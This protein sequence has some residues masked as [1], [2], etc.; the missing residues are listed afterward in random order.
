MGKSTYTT[1][2]V[3]GPF[4]NEITIHGEASAKK[5]SSDWGKGLTPLVIIKLYNIF[6]AP[7]LT[8][9]IHNFVQLW[10]DLVWVKMFNQ[11]KQKFYLE[12]M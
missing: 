12:N 10:N 8:N 9:F 3:Q 11:F 2:R 5:W 6:K 7:Q 4:M 1:L